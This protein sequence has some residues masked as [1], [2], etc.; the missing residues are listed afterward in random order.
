[1]F[2]V[3]WFLLSFNHKNR[4]KTNYTIIHF[5]A[6][7][8]TLL[9]FNCIL[10]KF[11]ISHTWRFGAFFYILRFTLTEIVLRKKNHHSIDFGH[12]FTRFLILRLIASRFLPLLMVYCDAQPTAEVELKVE[13]LKLFNQASGGRLVSVL[14]L[15]QACP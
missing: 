10:V 6:C 14:G 15:M 7:R 5:C 9:L 8:F 13:L 4:L 3:L 12:V 1:M 11:S 2:I